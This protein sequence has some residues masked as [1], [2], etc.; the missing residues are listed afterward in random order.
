MGMT[1]KFRDYLLGQNCVVYADNNPLSHLSTTKLGAT[2]PRWAAQLASSDFSIKYRSG[3]SN[4]N[5]NALSRQH[6]PS[7]HTEHVAPGTSVPGLLQVVEENQVTQ[8]TVSAFTCHSTPDLPVLQEADPIIKE[9]LTFW[10][11]KR[12]PDAAK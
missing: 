2:E 8:A 9:F 10:T 3:R 12:A 11:R 1:E 5:A 4:Q 7:I 6:P